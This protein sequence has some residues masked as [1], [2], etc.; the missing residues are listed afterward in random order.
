M[1]RTVCG[2]VPGQAG[3]LGCLFRTQGCGAS[4]LA[5]GLLP[6]GD[7]EASRPHDNHRGN[8]SDV[9]LSSPFLVIASSLDA[10]EVPQQ[11]RSAFRGFV[12]RNAE[13]IG[14]ALHDGIEVKER[15]KTAA[16]SK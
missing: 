7:R 4:Q 14:V 8:S 11:D 9:R 12:P 10:L 16:N 13:D 6:G 5:R 2:M 1:S 15:V 3:L